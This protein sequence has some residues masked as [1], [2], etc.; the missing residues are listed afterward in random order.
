MH[1]PTPFHEGLWAW[2]GGWSPG[3]RAYPFA[4]SRSAVGGSVAAR[5]A[6]APQWASPIT[7][8]GPRRALTGLPFPPTLKEG[9]LLDRGI[10]ERALDR[11]R[12]AG[13]GLGPGRLRVA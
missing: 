12:R 1:E 10:S 7:V 11:V 2:V 6:G 8:A 13:E 3:S 9:I 5:R 4:P